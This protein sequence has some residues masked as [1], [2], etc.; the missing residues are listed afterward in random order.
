LSGKLCPKLHVLVLLGGQWENR[1]H[2]CGQNV[3]IKIGRVVIA[4]EGGAARV[5]SPFEPCRARPLLSLSL[6]LCP[7][8]SHVHDVSLTFRQ[9]PENAVSSKRTH[10]GEPLRQDASQKF[11]LSWPRE[12]ER[13]SP[14]PG[15]CHT[16]THE[17]HKVWRV[18]G[19]SVRVKKTDLTDDKSKI[20]RKF[21]SARSAGCLYES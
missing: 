16:Q 21:E 11:V 9:P 19:A 2:G 17:V 1:S 5:H 8:P 6:S 7:T 12:E 15:M 18:C 20:L 3:A 4:D 10:R 13:L 14:A